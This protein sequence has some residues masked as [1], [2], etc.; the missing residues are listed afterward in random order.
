MLILLKKLPFLEVEMQR[1]SMSNEKMQVMLKEE[2]QDKV[3][4]FETKRQ[5]EILLEEADSLKA[6]L[7]LQQAKNN[8]LSLLVE[9]FQLKYDE[10]NVQLARMKQI[11]G[12]EEDGSRRFEDSFAATDYLGRNNRKIKNLSMIT[13]LAKGKEQRS[14]DRYA[15]A[16]GERE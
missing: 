6:N 3:D 5:Y 12:K 8:E 1:L 10:S 9:S 11:V 15:E 4:Y 13:S 2:R 16:D 14:S 7:N